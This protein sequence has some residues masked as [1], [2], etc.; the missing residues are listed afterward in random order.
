LEKFI[1]S[2]AS[3]SSRKTLE[4]YQLTLGRSITIHELQRVSIYM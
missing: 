4:V 3:G 2:R 1:K